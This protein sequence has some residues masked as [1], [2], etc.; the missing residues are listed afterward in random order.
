GKAILDLINGNRVDLVR[1]S[2]SGGDEWKQMVPLFKIIIPLP[3]PIEFLTVN[4]EGNLVPYIGWSYY[5]GL[6]VDT[7]GFYID[8]RTRIDINGGLRI[9]VSGDVK[10]LGAI[11]IGSPKLTI[12]AGISVSAGLHFNDPNPSDG[13][14]YFDELY[15]GNN[16]VNSYVDAL[17]FDVK[18]SA[19]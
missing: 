12:G 8:P 15:V 7:T 6:G 17:T 3:P 10:I 13:K 16:I 5:V 14:I 19:V 1:W 2:V 11:D 4:L 9:D 18:A